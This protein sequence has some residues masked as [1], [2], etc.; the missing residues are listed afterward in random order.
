M[1]LIYPPDV[2][3]RMLGA[4]GAEK[5]LFGSDYP[6]ILFPREETEPSLG[7]F[8]AQIS[9]AKLTAAERAVLLGGNAEHLL[10][11]SATIRFFPADDADWRG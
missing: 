7:R 2:L 9:D 3:D 4:V 10:R 5:V 8:I 1:P 6:L 11:R